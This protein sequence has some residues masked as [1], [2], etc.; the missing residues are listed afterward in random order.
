MFMRRRSRHKTTTTTSDSHWSYRRILMNY[1]GDFTDLCGNTW[2]VSGATTQTTGQSLGSG[3]MASCATS[4]YIQC[5]NS[6]FTI[7][8]NTAFKLEFFANPTWSAFGTFFEGFNP[9]KQAFWIGFDSS[10]NNKLYILAG[11][12]IFTNTIPTLTNGTPKWFCF[13]RTQVAGTWTLKLAVDGTEYLSTAHNAALAFDTVR[14]GNYSASAAYGLDGTLDSLRYTIGIDEGVTATPTSEFPIGNAGPAPT[15]SGTYSGNTT[16]YPGNTFNVTYS[17][18]GDAP[19]TVKLYC[20]STYIQTLTVS[21]TTINAS[22]YT[23]GAVTLQVTDSSGRTT[24]SSTL[25]TIFSFYLASVSASASSASVSLGGGPINLFATPDT[26]ASLSYAWYYKDPTMGS[27]SSSPFSTSQNPSTG[28]FGITGAWSFKVIASG[29]GLTS[30]E[31]EVF[32][33]CS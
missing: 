2:T 33:N 32:I 12:A 28:T 17:A 30:V 13:Y 6:S 1:N 19:L 15:V 8:A 31:G 16:L 11:S 10:N 20:G 18:T 5:V 14:I 21:P 24:T 23:N 26:N 29:S 22:R 9:G 3:C 25:A 4:K 27:Y 7:P